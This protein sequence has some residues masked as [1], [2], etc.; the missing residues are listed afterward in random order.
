MNYDANNIIPE[1][2]ERITNVKPMIIDHIVIPNIELL[3]KFPPLNEMFVL[4]KHFN[5][6]QSVI[7]H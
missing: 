7:Y 1:I 2:M 4:Q 6:R 5:V 3:H